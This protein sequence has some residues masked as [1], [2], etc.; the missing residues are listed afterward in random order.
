MEWKG[1]R[2][3]DN[4]E[5]HRG[6]NSG[7]PGG[8]PFGGRRGI[9]LPIGRGGSIGSVV[10]FVI[11]IVILHFMGV[12]V[13]QLLG[14]GSSQTSSSSYSDSQSAQPGANDEMKA[15]VGTVLAETEDA[16]NGIFAAAGRQYTEPRLVLYSGS[17]P[18]ACGAAS[19]ATGPFYCPPDQKVY[20]DTDF[21]RE[22]S[23]RFGASGDFAQAYVI[24][25][26][27][28]HHVQN[29]IG[30]LP[31]FNRAR[32]SMSETEANAMS[33]RVELQA[34]CFAGIWARFTDQRGLLEAGDIDEALNAAHQIGDD[35]LQRQAQGYVVPD[36]FTHGTSAQRAKWFRR[37]FDSGKMSA[38]DTFSGGV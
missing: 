27:V 29:L 11:V 18:S 21:F 26:E 9:N 1:R 7:G 8:D 19:S 25:H 31:K 3:S 5:D 13:G 35:A 34:D 23:D 16:W 24:A 12:D 32:Q 10:F 33:V 15:F 36:S 22:M 6:Q 37:G 28:G 2:Q 4:I 20:L 17:F 30:V 38:C 14:G